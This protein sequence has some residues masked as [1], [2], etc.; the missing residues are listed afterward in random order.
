MLGRIF[1]GFFLGRFLVALAVIFAFYNA[2]GFSYYHW[3]AGS[4]FNF[5]M[6]VVGLAFLFV[7]AFFIHSSLRAPAKF[8]YFTL[9]IFIFAIVWWMYD[10][11]WIS[12]TD[13]TVGTVVAQLFVAFALALGSVWS[14]IWRG[15][16]GQVTVDDPDT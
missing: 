7:F 14:I 11:G 8:V 6:I 12:L 15:G 4:G 2:T 13:P 16:T 3:V 10:S 5:G 1:S 9:L